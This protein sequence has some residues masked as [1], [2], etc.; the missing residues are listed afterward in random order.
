MALPTDVADSCF[1]LLKN[2]ESRRYSII[3]TKNE[4]NFDASSGTLDNSGFTPDNLYSG[5][6]PLKRTQNTPVWPMDF[7]EEYRRYD[8]CFTL[9]NGKQ[10][11]YMYVF[12]NLANYN[13]LNW[14]LGTHSLKIQCDQS[15]II[16]GSS[17]DMTSISEWLT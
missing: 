13:Q 6:A 16:S 10:T 3:L 17:S 15:S 11:S 1:N 12:V 14:V 2:D 4:V 7:N 5:C 8:N 9:T